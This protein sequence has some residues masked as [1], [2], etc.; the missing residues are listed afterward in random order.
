[1]PP[2]P[3]GGGHSPSIPKAAAVP[4][5]G[6]HGPS[7]APTPSRGGKREQ[8]EAN[9]G[10]TTESNFFVG[11]S[12]EIA[13]GGVFAATYATHP[14]GT[15]IEV[16]V[17]LPGGFET[18]INGVVRFVRDSMDFG[19]DSEPGMGVQFEGLTAEQRELILRFIRKRAPMFYDE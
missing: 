2:A 5:V 19:S 7:H 16:L 17:T 6:G 11:F 15:P 12:G 8:V 10:A 3:V 1:M 14:R 9:I 13:E 4:Q 18:K